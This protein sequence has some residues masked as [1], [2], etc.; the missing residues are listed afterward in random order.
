MRHNDQKNNIQVGMRVQITE[1]ILYDLYGKQFRIIKRGKFNMSNN[2]LFL[3]KGKDESEWWSHPSNF[4]LITIT[5]KDL[6]NI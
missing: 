1:R 5:I 2:E 4:E 6:I 3:L